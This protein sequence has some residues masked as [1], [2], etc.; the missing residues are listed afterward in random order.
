M[1]FNTS[2]RCKCPSAGER[3]ESWLLPSRNWTS[4]LTF[5]ISFGS[6]VKK[7]LD[8]SRILSLRSSSSI[9]PASPTF[10]GRT[11]KGEVLQDSCHRGR[12]LPMMQHFSAQMVGLWWESGDC[13]LA[14]LSLVSSKEAGPRRETALLQVKTLHM[15]EIFVN[16]HRKPANHQFV[17]KSDSDTVYY[18]LEVIG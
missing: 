14:G 5:S 13:N 6:S 11:R 12:A 15:S 18:I 1:N 16:I 17:T 3:I 10:E 7:L 9:L 4:L 8:K 2:R